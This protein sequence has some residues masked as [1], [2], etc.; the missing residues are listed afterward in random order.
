MFSRGFKGEIKTLKRHNLGYSD[1][2]F[3]VAFIL[4]FYLFRTVPIVHLLGETFR[5]SVK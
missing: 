3:G 1:L 2:L 5:G 4:L